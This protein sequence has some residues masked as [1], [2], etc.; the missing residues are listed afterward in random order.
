LHDVVEKVFLAGFRDQFFTEALISSRSFI[1]VFLTKQP[2]STF[3][4][5]RGAWNCILGVNPAGGQSRRQNHHGGSDGCAA[6]LELVRWNA[7]ERYEFFKSHAE[8][9]QQRASSDF[10]AAGGRRTWPYPYNRTTAA[11][12]TGGAAADEASDQRR[13]Q[14]FSS[15]N[16]A[17]SR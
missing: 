17:A 13:R 6:V 12:L 8:K 14:S 2:F 3:I 16:T 1:F 5:F 7:R 11:N 4:L 15:P 9:A 10:P